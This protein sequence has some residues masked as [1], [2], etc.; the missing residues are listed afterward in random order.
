MRKLRVVPD[1]TKLQFMWLRRLT[2]PV[3]AVLV[4]ASVLGAFD[5]ALL[6][7]FPQRIFA[8][9]RSEV[10]VAVPL[11]VEALLPGALLGREQRLVRLEQA[12]IADRLVASQPHVR[13]AGRQLG[14]RH[15]W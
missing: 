7:A 12:W 6:L 15:G 2:F 3:S 13:F 5:P 14:R 9:M 8:V 10:L 1:G 11:E 4:V